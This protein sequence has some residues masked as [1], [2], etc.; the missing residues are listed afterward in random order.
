MNI[1]ELIGNLSNCTDEELRNFSRAI[2]V[3]QQERD[4]EQKRKG[5]ETACEA[6][7]ALDKLLQ[8]TITVEVVGDYAE[9][10]EGE[11]DL[12]ELCDVLREYLP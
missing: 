7:E 3:V 6:L 8:Q 9:R 4:D 12:L 10:V 5:I 11:L 2:C 1:N